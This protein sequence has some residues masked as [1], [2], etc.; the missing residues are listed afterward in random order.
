[1]EHGQPP[2]NSRRKIKTPYAER[3][4][5][6]H[7]DMKTLYFASDGHA[8]LGKMDIFKATRPK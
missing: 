8:G 7:P 3:T 5:F 1:M 2:V 4:P 6:L